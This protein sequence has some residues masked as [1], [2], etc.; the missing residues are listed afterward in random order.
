MISYGGTIEGEGRLGVLIR[1]NHA[2]SNRVDPQMLF[3]KNNIFLPFRVCLF[4]IYCNNRF[5]LENICLEKHKKNKTLLVLY[6]ADFASW[7]W[8]EIPD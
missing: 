1:V 8:E 7:A 2:S 3:W 4:G 5:N 6:Y